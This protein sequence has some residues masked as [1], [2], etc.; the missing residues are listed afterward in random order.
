M[1][2][3][4]L[5]LNKVFPI[6]IPIYNIDLIIMV[7][8]DIPALKK[9]LEELVKEDLR[10][11]LDELWNQHDISLKGYYTYND[12]L[13]VI[14]I[15]DM[16]D[17]HEFISVLSHEILHAVFNIAK[18]VGLKY[19][20]KSE[21]AYTYLVGYITREIYKQLDENIPST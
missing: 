14:Y 16:E 3:K 5:G 7:G 19:S 11:K 15:S 2:N 13:K 21:E 10:Y 17:Y 4:Y 6:D 9:Q 20:D 1:K 8:D 18:Y 12:P